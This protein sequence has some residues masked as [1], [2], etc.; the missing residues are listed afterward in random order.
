MSFLHWAHAALDVINAILIVD[1]C[2]M[3]LSVGTSVLL[4]L[5]AS[6]ERKLFLIP[7][8]LLDAL[9]VMCNIILSVFFFSQNYDT[10][11]GQSTQW[12]YFVCIFGLLIFFGKFP[13]LF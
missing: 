5:G 3:F 2:V 11:M 4:F 10:I 7:A 6:M 1:A 13:G 9:Y 8:L 12:V